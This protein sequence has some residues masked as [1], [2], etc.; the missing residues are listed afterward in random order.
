M[1]LQRKEESPHC[2]CAI[3]FVLLLISIL[4]EIHS[5]YSNTGVNLSGPNPN[6]LGEQNRTS[7]NAIISLN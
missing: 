7:N 2:L 3:Y 6:S 5:F 4:T 1:S